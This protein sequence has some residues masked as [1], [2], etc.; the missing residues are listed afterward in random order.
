MAVEDPSQST[1][2]SYYIYKGMYL[3]KDEPI[4]GLLRKLTS[5]VL[6]H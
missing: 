2:I 3:F 1:P 6:Y 5:Q 4:T